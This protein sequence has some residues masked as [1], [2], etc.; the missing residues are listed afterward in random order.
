MNF[1][2]DNVLKQTLQVEIKVL[3]QFPMEFRSC[4]NLAD[5]SVNAKAQR[6]TC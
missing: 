3:M 6:F 1:R 4:I 2:F 5:R